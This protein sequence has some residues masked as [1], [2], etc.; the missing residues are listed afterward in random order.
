MNDHRSFLFAPAASARKMEKALASEADAVIFDLEDSVALAEKDPARRAVAALLANARSKPVYVRI[1]GTTTEH[2]F[3]D[4]L[5]IVPAQPDGIVLPKTE[6][7]TELATVDWTIGQMEA[8]HGHA[9]GAIEI[10]PIVETARG[11]GTVDDI[12][13]ASPRVRRMALGAVDLALDMGLDL[14]DEAGALVMPRF[15]V[16]RASRA[17]GLNAPLDTAWVDIPDIAGFRQSAERARAMGYRGKCC[18]H[19][20]QVA[21]A[22]VVFTPDHEQVADACR[23][24]EAFEAAEVSGIAA[25]SVDGRMIDYPVVEAARRLLARAQRHGVC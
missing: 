1:N 19:P 15:S 10:M 2:C 17:A 7:A 13:R 11:L 6:S 3:R 12:A 25:I 22:N 20:S 5:E 21:V 24:V 9:G 14:R 8:I 4:L 16:A 18:I 23:I